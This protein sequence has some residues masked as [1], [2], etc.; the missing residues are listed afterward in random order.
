MCSGK[1]VRYKPKFVKTG[2]VISGVD[3]IWYEASQGCAKYSHQILELPVVLFIRYDVTIHTHFMLFLELPF[4]KYQNVHKFPFLLYALTIAC[5]LLLANIKFNRH[6][7]INLTGSASHRK[8]HY[9]LLRH[10]NW[11]SLVRMMAPCDQT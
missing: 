3:C 4:A 9:P 2:F 11:E 5:E 1:S 8:I 7:S 10:L 6:A